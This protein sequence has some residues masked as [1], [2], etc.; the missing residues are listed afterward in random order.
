MDLLV[1]KEPKLKL[2]EKIKNADV[3]KLITEKP[4]LGDCPNIYNDWGDSHR[5]IA[6]IKNA[7]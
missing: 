2:A 6:L 4:N 7:N 5:G 3:S 1:K